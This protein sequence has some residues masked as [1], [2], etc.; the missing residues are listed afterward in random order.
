[1]GYYLLQYSDK[2]KNG[3]S[4]GGHV[5]LCEEQYEE[6][7]EAL[8][9]SNFYGMEFYAGELVLRYDTVCDI[10][11]KLEIKIIS[12]ETVEHYEEIGFIKSGWA[13]QFVETVIETYEEYC[14]FE[15]AILE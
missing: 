11:K 1:M 2:C 12:E 8:N 9:V 15:D 4:V 3:V 7:M 10:R 6:L 14:E 13:E 5:L